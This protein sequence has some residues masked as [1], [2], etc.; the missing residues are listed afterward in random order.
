MAGAV[1]LSPSCSPGGGGS[2]RPLRRFTWFLCTR[3]GREPPCTPPSL[4]L[5]PWPNVWPQNPVG[6][7]GLV[8]GAHPASQVG[9]ATVPY[10]ITSY[11][12]QAGRIVPWWP[13]TPSHGQHRCPWVAVLRP[14]YPAAYIDSWSPRRLHVAPG[15][16]P[17]DAPPRLATVH[18][19]QCTKVITHAPSDIFY[20][21]LNLTTV[22]CVQVLH[23]SVRP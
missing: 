18:G 20:P 7:P 17:T 8:G 21:V 15:H 1:F 22:R 9:S 16:T 2:P 14:S 5:L 13:G 4:S 6:G 23:P 19:G 12:L 3:G 10:G 11:H